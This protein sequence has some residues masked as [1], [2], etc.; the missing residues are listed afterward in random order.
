M[1]LYR[2]LIIGVSLLFFVL[3]AGVEAIYLANSRA[4]LQEQLSSQA[5]DAATTLALR[6]AAARNLDDRALIETLINPVFDRGYFSEIRVVS[7]S[8]DV[9]ARRVLAPAQG[10]VPGWFT[11]LFPVDAPG[12]QSLV[13]SGWREL[14]RVI[15]AS[16]PNFAYQ[17]LWHIGL[18]TI[19]WLLLIYGVSIAAIV[20]FLAM[21]LRPLKEIEQAAVAIGERNFRTI[22]LVPRTR[23]L[24]RVVSAMNDMSG[25]IRQMIEEETAR[26][27]HLRNDAFIDPLTL[28]YNRRGF[29]R[30]LQALIKSK[31]DVFSGALAL[32]EIDG[33]AQFNAAAGY[34]RGDEILVQLGSALVGA[35]EGA[36]AVCGRISGTGFSFA[37][38]NVG[39]A[40]LE[41]MV[42]KVCA[43]FGLVLAEQG[44]EAQLHYHCGATRCDGAL[45]EFS[46]LLAAADHALLQAREKG[47]N[48][49]EI[50]VF[51]QSISDGSQA[52]RSRI[53]QA[54]E[55]GRLA[56]FAQNAL[57]LPG[58]NIA[59]SEITV[60]LLT[61]DGEPIP[62]AQF[63]PMAARHRLLGRLDCVVI[64]K[65][66]D[67]LA[68]GGTDRPVLAL[69]I[70]ARTIADTEA[71]RRILGLLDARKNV[72]G[73]LIFEMTEFGAT[74]DL[75]HAQ[76]FRGEVR[77]RG[78]HFA[79]D[80]FGML[81]DSLKLVHSLRPYYI[82]L[83]SAYLRELSVNADSRFLVESVVKIARALDIGIF[84][85]AVED[86]ALVPLL[87]ELG[88][89]GYQGYATEVPV[90]IV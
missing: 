4:Q 79:L 8:G 52:W 33:F 17:Q 10:D 34:Q 73:R 84:A 22:A 66:L 72:A 55:S 54:L 60:R 61:E 26:A 3:L 87:I 9:L 58:R 13:S 75:A 65:L 69:N 78:A 28:V 6:L 50:S 83:S 82:K 45:P 57:V 74:Q 47:L 24:A 51:D 80:N 53:E 18:Q 14:G 27:E 43:T 63:L 35:S 5:Q 86:E 49:Y 19:L 29:R 37:A 20:G 41:N 1:T 76:R 42:A 40:E 64:E 88:F 67:F 81:R 59:H 48:Q 36:T 89:S 30:Q 85:Q 25:R 11:R 44:T 68:S 70:S 46:A 2:Q 71:M 77:K 32:L 16:H 21:L 23:E 7:N 38:I 56:L 90:R 31:S 15:V 39:A 12:A 62:A